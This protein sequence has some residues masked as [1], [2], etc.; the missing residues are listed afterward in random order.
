MAAVLL[1]LVPAANAA[2]VTLVAGDSDGNSSFDSGMNWSDGQAP[3][4][5]KV[6]VTGGVEFRW[7]SAGGTHIFQGDSLTLGNPGV[8]ASNSGIG[9]GSSHATFVVAD[10][11]VNGTL[12][13]SRLGGATLSGKITANDF[14]SFFLAESSGESV[15]LTLCS[16]LSGNGN[17]YL[18]AISP[19]SSV[20]L[21]PEGI[22]AFTGSIYGYG[23]GLIDVLGDGAFASASAVNLIADA[24]M[25]ISGG[26]SHDYFPDFALVSFL[27][28]GSSME[29][30]FEGIDKIGGIF[31]Y[32]NWLAP[33]LYGAKG[34][35]LAEFTDQH[36]RGTGL[37]RV[38]PEPGALTLLLLSLG[39]LLFR[40]RI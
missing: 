29:L 18:L 26:V 14:D 15:S 17:I 39:I 35:P 32:G 31:A 21:A 40:R 5:G 30:D 7:P 9:G 33:G 38:I 19:E 34:N 24:G 37:L 8:S 3:R 4:A 12:A 16:T 11:R 1:L 27:Q 36:L 6:Y 2:V 20:A 13:V 23:Q 25:R 10:L 22:G 28:D